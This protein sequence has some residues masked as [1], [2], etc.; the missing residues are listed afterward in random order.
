LDCDVEEPNAHI[1]LNPKEVEEIPVF[2]PVPK[3]NEK[4]FEE[5]CH[6]CICC[7]LVCRRSAIEEE[8]REIGVLKV[9]RDKKLVYGELK[10][11][12][13]RATPL[14]REVKKFAD[15]NTVI[16]CPPGIGCPSIASVGNVDK[17]MLVVEPTKSGIHDFKRALTLLEHFGVKTFACINFFDLN[18]ELTSEIEKICE[19]HGIEVIGKI[20]FDEAVVEAMMNG[21]SVVE[22]APKSKAAIAIA[23]V[24]AEI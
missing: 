18:L 13:A 9:C 10:V 16:D 2:V 17:A 3:V 15:K 21:K 19:A 24:W 5:L 1:F 23:E 14:I 6:G 4:C 7:K 20:P 11:G 8:R 12:E 22:F